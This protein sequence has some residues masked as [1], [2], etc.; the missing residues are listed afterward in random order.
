[1]IPVYEM[2]IV[3]SRAY[4]RKTMPEMQCVRNQKTGQ[5]LKLDVAD[6]SL[7][8]EYPHYLPFFVLKLKREAL[9]DY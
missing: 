5:W 3:C 2:S 6:K 4:D 8:A 7:H 1:M 9:T